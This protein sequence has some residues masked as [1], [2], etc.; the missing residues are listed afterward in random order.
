MGKFDIQFSIEDMTERL[1]TVHETFSNKDYSMLIHELTSNFNRIYSSISP[2][3]FETEDTNQHYLDDIIQRAYVSN[4]MNISSTVACYLEQSIKYAQKGHFDGLFRNFIS[5][6]HERLETLK[7]YLPSLEK[8]LPLGELSNKQTQELSYVEL[9]FELQNYRINSMFSKSFQKESYLP[10]DD[11]E[12]FFML[13]KGETTGGF[14][15]IVNANND[16]ISDFDYFSNILI[17][18]INNI[19]MHAYNTENDIHGRSQKEFRKGIWIHGSYGSA[20]SDEKE[21]DGKYFI[22]VRDNGF[23][24]QPD[25]Y[26]K[27]FKEQVST[28]TEPGEHGIGLL[29]VKKILESRGGSIECKT[30]LGKDTKFYIMIPCTRDVNHVCYDANM[31]K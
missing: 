18:L 28:K 8:L 30:E 9:L 17:P 27:L 16:I 21:E 4:L 29:G 22:T 10:M 13:N 2:F 19:I 31:K 5:G 14:A 3:V 12:A 1:K 20:Y 7:S 23:G 25:V 26:E 6:T 11:A 15:T 24:I